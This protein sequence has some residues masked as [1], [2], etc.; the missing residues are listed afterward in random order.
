[1]RIVGSSSENGA[2]PP[3]VK[4]RWVKTPENKYMQIDS[5]ARTVPV[6]PRKVRADR[7]ITWD[8]SSGIIH[9]GFDWFRPGRRQSKQTGFDK[10]VCSYNLTTELIYFLSWPLASVRCLFCP[11]LRNQGSDWNDARQTKQKGKFV[12]NITTGFN[13]LYF[14]HLNPPKS[15]L[16]LQFTSSCNFQTL[17]SQLV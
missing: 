12:I 2:S 10:E 8:H 3:A 17:E 1:M 16:R 14:P 15:P 6:T 13:I 5:W 7:G 4:T 9:S 11:F